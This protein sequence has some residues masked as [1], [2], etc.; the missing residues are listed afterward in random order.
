MR[1]LGALS[2]IAGGMGFQAR[3]GRS[4]Q[5]DRG[6]GEKGVLRAWETR[7]VL[8]HL[9]TRAVESRGCVGRT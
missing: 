2:G 4:R 6:Q 1:K 9:G 3:F 5:V 8:F 7:A